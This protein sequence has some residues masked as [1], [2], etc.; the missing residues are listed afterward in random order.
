[1][2]EEMNQWVQRQLAS[3]SGVGP[4]MPLYSEAY[5][6]GG[7]T[8]GRSNGL[9]PVTPFGRIEAPGSDRAPPLAF[10]IIIN[11]IIYMNVIITA[12]D[13]RSVSK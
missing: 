1:M 5:A 3:G 11:V 8:A 2:L 4:T 7:Q 6:F 13:S 12:T 9:G 10:H